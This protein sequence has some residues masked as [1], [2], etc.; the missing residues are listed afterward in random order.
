MQTWLATITEIYDIPNK[1]RIKLATVNG[2]QSIV[3]A[4][5][6]VGDPVVYIS[7]QSI[8]PPDLITFLGL[9][10]RLAGADKNRVK[11]I[12]MGGVLSQGIIMRAPTVPDFVDEDGLDKWFGVTKWE[13][14]IPTHLSGKVGRPKGNAPIAPMYD[15]ENIKKQRHLRFEYDNR[16]E[17]IGEYWYDPFDGQQVVVTEKLHGTNFAAHMN[18]GDTDAYIYSKGLGKNGH[19]LLESDENA[20]WKAF[21]MYPEIGMFLRETLYHM[22]DVDSVTVRGEIIGEGIQDLTYGYKFDVALFSV[23]HHIAGE[24]KCYHPSLFTR[25]LDV[26]HIPELYRGGYDYDMCV[27]LSVG[28]NLYGTPGLHVRE[29]VV[30]AH[31]TQYRQTNGNRYAAKFINP[32]YLTRKGGTEYN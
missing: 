22:S 20:Y 26:P 3:S 8:L 4:D 9:E 1:D 28:T 21:R 25:L 30:V 7:E 31:A 12:K 15:I 13:P 14:S 24:V 18:R 11:A 29:G 23:E 32:D 17:I 27:S 2:Y 16:G 5:Y 19:V 6:K 10:G